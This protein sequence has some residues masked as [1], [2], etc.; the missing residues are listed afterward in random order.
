MRMNQHE[1]CGLTGECKAVT[2]IRCYGCA[3]QDKAS[4]KGGG[5]GSVEH[6]DWWQWHCRARA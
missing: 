3:G 6:C 2:F 4:S 5:S 1:L